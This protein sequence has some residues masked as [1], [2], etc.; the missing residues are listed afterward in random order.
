MRFALDHQKMYRRF[1]LEKENNQSS[2]LSRPVI[3]KEFSDESAERAQLHPVAGPSTW[4]INSYPAGTWVIGLAK[5]DHF[6]SS[7]V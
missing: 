1:K 2:T 5:R 6:S 4:R 3:E 7:K